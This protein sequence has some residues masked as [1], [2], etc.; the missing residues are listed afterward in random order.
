M[1]KSN[2]MKR[3]VLMIIGAALTLSGMAQSKGQI[4]KD[5]KG[6]NTLSVGYSGM[7]SITKDE[8]YTQ[9]ENTLANGVELNYMK[10]ISVC[11]KQ[12]LF[13]EAGARLSYNTDSEKDMLNATHIKMRCNFLALTIP[14]NLTYRLKLSNGIMIAPLA[15]VH[16]RTNIVGQ[17]NSKEYNVAFSWKGDIDLFDKQDM[18]GYAY[19]RV[20][21]GGQVGVNLA[22][23][24]I[25]VGV[26]GYFDSPIFNHEGEKIVTRDVA[27]TIGH[28]F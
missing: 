7:R 6:Y 13:V 4:V 19:N 27:V 14:V 21:G 15:G 17:L 24:Q 26:T 18:G 25:C 9:R 8:Y 16:L 11:K 1:I 28:S 3:L 22:W 20:Q 12:P 23:K 2:T 10:G 5:T